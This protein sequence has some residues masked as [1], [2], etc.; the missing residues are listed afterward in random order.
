MITRNQILITIAVCIFSVKSLAQTCTATGAQIN[1][2]AQVVKNIKTDF[3]AVGNGV[4]DDHQAFVNAATFINSQNG[5]VKLIIPD[6]IYIVGKQ[7]AHLNNTATDYDPVYEGETIMEFQNVINV[8]IIGTSNSIIIFKDSMHFGTFD[9]INGLVP[10]DLNLY[11]PADTLTSINRGSSYKF[12]GTTGSL[13]LLN[14]CENI[15]IK[16]LEINGNNENYILGGNWG[17]GDRPIELNNSYGIQIHNSKNITLFD[18]KTH[19]AGNDNLII[20]SWFINGDTSKPRTQNILIEN[21]VSEYAGRNGFSWVG[22]KDFCVINSTFNHAA[23]TVIRTKPGY[24][25]DIEPEPEPLDSLGVCN[26]GYFL[27]C[28]FKN[29]HSLG[30]TTGASYD[31]P[32]PD[33]L[34]SNYLYTYNHYFKNCTVVG[35]YEAAMHNFINRTTF[36]GCK[37]YGGVIEK[38]STLDVPQQPATYKNC[39]FTDCYNGKFM[40][41]IGYNLGISYA[42]KA[43]FDSCRFEKYRPLFPNLYAGQPI[44]SRDQD[45]LHQC[46]DD[47]YNPIIKNSVFNYFVQPIS[48]N[49]LSS[50]TRKINFLNNSFFKNGSNNI[51]WNSYVGCSPDQ[52]NVDLGNGLQYF[53]WPPGYVYPD[54]AE[55]LVCQDNL[56]ISEDETVAQNHQTSSYIISDAKLIINNQN[57]SYKA[58]NYIQLNAGFEATV[59][60]TAQLE[61]AIEN[62]TQPP[63]SNMQQ[64][65]DVF[66]SENAQINNKG[67]KIYP[68]PFR[69]V[70]TIQLN[71]RTDRKLLYYELTNFLGQV[72]TKKVFNS[73]VSSIFN[74]TPN[75][76]PGNY[77]IKL[78][79]TDEVIINKILKL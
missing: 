10:S 26:N 71:S 25:M 55:K 56:F 9:T 64:Q 69:D 46:S 23:R 35:N 39:L 37:F 21:F 22:G 79:F 65:H 14:E 44:I 57:S 27:N 11:N 75:I 15:E 42:Y 74:I 60:G 28:S 31:S 32:V 6:G 43:V 24:G 40:H 41:F 58:S 66:V 30:F 20:S 47:T 7:T 3:G 29:N 68:N 52:G 12:A 5:N 78:Y 62:C 18:L 38:G 45:P 17:I 8:S 53:T 4:N 63:P 33:I 51:I 49:V 19:H 16:S 67:L 50:N 70:I 59:S 54:C 1:P 77:L 73:K 2:E 34:G 72:V 36:D 76:T 48:S 13:M 61:M